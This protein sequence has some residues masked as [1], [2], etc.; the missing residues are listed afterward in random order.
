MSMSLFAILNKT[1]VPEVK[2]W[3]AEIDDAGFD[4]KLDSRLVPYET[5]GFLPCTLFG[6]DA[7]F[8]IGYE[9]VEELPETLRCLAEGRDV[10][11]SFGW[12][13]SLLE[14]ASAMT[15]AYAL[16][17]ERDAVVLFEDQVLSTDMEGFRVVLSEFLE[18]A[19]TG[20]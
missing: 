6:D 17:M 19:K 12:S 15:A 13:S 20:M 11:I 14:G 8:E 4:L 7:G 16:A 10:C 3:Q 2:D 9:G 18:I 1:D 5:S